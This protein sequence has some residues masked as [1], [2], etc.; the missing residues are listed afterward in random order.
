MSE[1]QKNPEQENA[2]YEEP[3]VE[4]VENPDGPAVTAAGVT[5]N[6]QS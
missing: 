3:S 6:G 2:E 5:I 4:D 1:E